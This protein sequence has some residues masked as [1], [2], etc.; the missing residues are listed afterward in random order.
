MRILIT[1]ARGQLGRAVAQVAQAAGNEVI[2]WDRDEADITKPEVADLVQQQLPNVL[3]NCA[4]WTNVDGAESD[5]QGAFALNALGPRYLA[6]GCAECGALMVQIS[7]N[8]VFAGA[9]GRF[10]YEYE[11]CA[12]NSAYARSK[13]AGEVAVLS[14]GAR[15]IVARTAW[16]FGPGGNNFPGKIVAAA[17]KQG[18]LRVVNDEFGNPTYSIDAAVAILQLAVA[19]RTGIYHLVNE[20]YASRFDFAETVL[21]A[22]GLGNVPLTPISRTEWAR[23]SQP[24]PHAVLVNQ[25]ARAAGV[26]LRPWQE[27]TAE[28]AASLQQEA[29]AA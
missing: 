1:G 16:L 27:S 26:T 8:E 15:A 17:R 12:P 11:E 19:G 2:A 21:A 10:Y 9:P 18:A 4:A 3:V 28:Y 6:Q 7:S 23:P 5:P 29:A 13:R 20:G 14:T 22:A 24:P 25:A